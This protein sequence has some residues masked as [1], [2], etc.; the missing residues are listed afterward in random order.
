MFIKHTSDLYADLLF[1]SIL[2]FEIGHIFRSFFSNSCKEICA[3]L[4]RESMVS[5]KHNSNTA[6][7]QADVVSTNSKTS[8]LYSSLEIRISVLLLIS[9]LLASRRSVHS[10]HF[11]L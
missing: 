7:G 2:S 4:S 1:C 5:V 9:E 6:Q 3:L 11:L 8:I 10:S